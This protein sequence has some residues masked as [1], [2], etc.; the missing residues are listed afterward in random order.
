[1]ALEEQ[2]E[3]SAEAEARA[4]NLATAKGQVGIHRLASESIN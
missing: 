3:I 2:S 4:E 1:M